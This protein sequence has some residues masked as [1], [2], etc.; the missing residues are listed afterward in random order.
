[1][2]LISAKQLLVLDTLTPKATVLIMTQ[3]SN[4][5]KK[6]NTLN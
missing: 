4:E 6:D 3:I 1:M 2:I 5:I